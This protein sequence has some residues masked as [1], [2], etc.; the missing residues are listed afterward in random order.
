MKG[1]IH[2]FMH[3]T[4]PYKIECFS[5]L[6]I[7]GFTIFCVFVPLLSVETFYVFVLVGVNAPADLELSPLHVLL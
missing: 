4:E 1:L 3:C 7:N 6:L 2:I 5:H